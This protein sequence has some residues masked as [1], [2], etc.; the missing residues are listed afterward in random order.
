ML[1]LTIVVLIV[2][3][4]LQGAIEFRKL[5]ASQ[6]FNVEEE[7]VRPNPTYWLVTGA[8]LLISPK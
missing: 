1:V 6:E 7:G 3:D 2:G 5:I 4:I 8:I